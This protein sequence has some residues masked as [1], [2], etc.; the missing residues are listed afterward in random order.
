MSFLKHENNIFGQLI[1]KF[2][3]YKAKTKFGDII[4]THIGYRTVCSNKIKQKLYI[5][6]RNSLN[7]FRE[8]QNF[9]KKVKTTKQ[10]F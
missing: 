3:W 4:Q 1:S 9:E 8:F 10:A 2:M 5:K 7:F 6:C